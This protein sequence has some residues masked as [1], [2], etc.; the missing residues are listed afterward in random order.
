M[1]ERDNRIDPRELPEDMGLAVEPKRRKPKP[2]P[3]QSKT[4]LKVTGALVA[5]FVLSSVIYNWS[6]E[7]E[8]PE[9]SESAQGKSE[10]LPEPAVDHREQ[11]WVHER[12][13]MRG[14][15]GTSHAVIETLAVGSQLAVISQSGRWSKVETESGLVGYIYSPL[16]KRER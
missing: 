7:S 12:V 11:R 2:R 16:L 4:W 15:A 5:L 14:G 3:E 13:N 8:T 10:P 1:R 6:G 9:S